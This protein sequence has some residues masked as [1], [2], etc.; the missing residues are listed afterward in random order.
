MVLNI[1]KNNLRV[2]DIA[3]YVKRVFDTSEVDVQK[4][5]STSVDISVTGK[6]VLHS[7]EGLKEL[8][9]YF[10]DYDVRIY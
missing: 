4:E 10:K 2:S 1:V 7:L 8:E 9:Y 5:H 6:N 3:N